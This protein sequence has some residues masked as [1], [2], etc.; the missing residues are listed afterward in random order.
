MDLLH[1]LRTGEIKPPSGAKKGVR[2]YDNATAF[3]L[4]SAHRE[5]VARERAIRDDE[6]AE[7]VLAS[8]DAKLDR[9]RE[10]ALKAAEA[11]NEA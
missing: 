10:R 8:I 2:T 9:M 5:A 11:A 7:A 4:L 1:R 6:D 3:R